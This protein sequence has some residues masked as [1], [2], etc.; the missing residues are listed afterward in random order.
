MNKNIV[1][2]VGFVLIGII[3]YQ[4]YLLDKN[5]TTPLIQAKEEQPEINIEIEKKSIEK[6][7][8]KST[9]Q[10]SQTE[11]N[12][13]EMF[14]EELIKEDL[15][16][17]FKNIFGNPKL[18]EGIKE[19]L[20]EAELQLQEGIKEMEKG[21]GDLNLELEKLSQSDPFFKDLFNTLTNKNQLQLTDRGKDYY[22]SLNI[23]G[24]VNSKIDIK[25][26]DGFLTI[27]ILE[28]IEKTEQKNNTTLHT[29]SIK[30]HKNTLFIPSDAAIDELK[31]EYKN[32]TLEI[33]IPKISNS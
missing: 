24:G 6:E 31:T 26:K 23:D 9:M 14:D 3:A 4:A 13:N 16:R 27:S 32:N 21:F 33:T 8:N 5:S 2:I 7:I 30:E 20:K 11:F 28:N 22:L 15:N 19:G 18:Q 17:L 1:T 12:S 29:K 10:I 25:T